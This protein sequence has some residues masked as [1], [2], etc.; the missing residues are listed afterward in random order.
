VN[1]K[2]FNGFSVVLTFIALCLAGCQ[3]GPV[4]EGNL[5]LSEYESVWQ[6]LKVYSIYQD[7][8]PETPFTLIDKG[9]SSPAA[10]LTSIHDT[11]RGFTYTKYIPLEPATLAY[12]LPK[13]T[14]TAASPGEIAFQPLT[15]STAVVVIASFSETTYREFLRKIPPASMFSNIIVDL[16]FNPGGDIISLD[17]IV[18]AF[19]PTNTPYI[20]ARYR[21]YDTKTKVARTV[22]WSPWK[23]FEGPLPELRNKKL[24]VL[25]NEGSASAA[26]IFAAGLKDGVSALLLGE[27]SYGKAIGQI[28]I[29]RRDRDS[30]QIT[31]LQLKGLSNR[32]GEYGNG[33]GIV[34]DTVPDSV[35]MSGMGITDIEVRD[36]WYAIKMLEPSADRSKLLLRKTA[37]LPPKQQGCFLVSS[38]D[39][40]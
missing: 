19:L 34:P 26:E 28:K 14:L 38:P 25:I 27:K 35:V 24:A 30:L 32:I 11:L 7:R 8:V 40:L 37:V 10:L 2:S 39:P 23:S 6:Y 31:Y 15:D 21:D 29:P 3:L 18:S 1:K 22:E 12:N 36:L 17:S 4:Y 20:N 9:D 5:D 13:S 16:R 33:K